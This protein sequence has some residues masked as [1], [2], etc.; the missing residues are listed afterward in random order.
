MTS[1][2][3]LNISGESEHPFPVLDLGGKYFNVYCR[4]ILAV[5]LAFRAFIRSPGGKLYTCLVYAADAQG[6]LLHHLTTVA[7]GACVPGTYGNMEI[8]GT[9]LNKLSCLRYSVDSGLR[10]SHHSFCE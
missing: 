1:N 10:H 8:D 2:T 7:G 5:S 3:V 4:V 6:T 9:V